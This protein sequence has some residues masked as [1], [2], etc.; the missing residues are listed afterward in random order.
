MEKIDIKKIIISKLPTF[1]TKFPNF[2]KKILIAFLERILLIKK[3]NQFIEKHNEKQGLDFIDEF[4]DSF[5]ISYLISQ[6]DRD[7]IPSEGRVIVVANHPFGGLDGMILL[8]LLLSIRNDVKVIV[9]D[10]LLNITN[11]KEHFLPF[12]LFSTNKFRENYQAIT[13]SLNEESA[14]IIFPAGEVSRLKLSG[15]KDSKWKKGVIHFVD[16]FQAPVLPIFIKGRNSLLF[17]FVSLIS[18]KLS[19]FLLPYEL[20][21][22]EKKNIEIKIGN[23]I[24][25]KAFSTK[26]YNPEHLS[27]SLRKHLYKIAKDKP[28]IFETESTVIQPVDKQKIKL[29]LNNNDCIGTT[30]DGKKIYLV[31]YQLGKDVVREISRLRE[32]T[33]RKVGEGT[34]KSKDFDNYDKHYKHLILWDDDNLEIVGAY[35][36]G[37]GEQVLSNYGKEGF[38]TYSLFEFSDDFLR[39][40]PKSIE[41]GRSFIQSKY[42]NSM[43]LDYL[44]QGIG[45]VLI[46]NP[47]IRYLFGP[48]S[49]SNNY[50]EEAKNLIVYF[51][52]KWFSKNNNLVFSKNKFNLSDKRIS[53][54]ESIFNLDN[55]EQELKI[56]KSRLK[57]LG[58]SVPVLFKQYSDICYREGVNFVDFNIDPDFNNCVDAFIILDL[59][60]IKESKKSRY[61][62]N[63][64]FVKE[65]IA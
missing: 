58:F 34:G 17:Y 14:L 18:K 8:K 62:S 31:D 25:P 47:G 20:M 15:I 33:F 55:Y 43:A 54:L 46:S 56:L 60:F 65:K 12:D 11:L 28:G 39:I 19:M 38:Y 29:Q 30:N 40:L 23:L 2:I 24:S 7:K 27:K 57:I 5:D 42:W 37:F 61:L 26:Y 22:K 6:R 41:L 53:E 64:Y 45:K 10:V 9:N 13:K 1:E 32:I 21:N 59:N 3:I 16:K 49:I 48:V 52:K 35:R 36:F 63:T 51:F 50:S 4:F 44:W